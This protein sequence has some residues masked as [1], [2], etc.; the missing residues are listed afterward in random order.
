MPNYCEYDTFGRARRKTRLKPDNEEPFEVL[1]SDEERDDINKNVQQD[2]AN[3]LS[4]G[5][6]QFFLRVGFATRLDLL[7]KSGAMPFNCR[8]HSL[9]NISPLLYINWKTG[10]TLFFKVE[11][12]KDDFIKAVIEVGIHR[13]IGY[14]IRN[15][16]ESFIRAVYYAMEQAALEASICLDSKFPYLGLKKSRSPINIV[17]EHETILAKDR[18]FTQ[19]DYPHVIKIGAYRNGTECFGVGRNK[20]F[21]AVQAAQRIIVNDDSV[22]V[23]CTRSSWFRELVDQDFDDVKLEDN[24]PENA[25]RPSNSNYEAD[26]AAF[27]ADLDR[28]ASESRQ[29]LLDMIDDF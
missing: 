28:D 15:E 1:S 11:Y 10:G 23:Y 13:C 7:V 19:S 25:D 9:Q 14:S 3:I 29:E 20:Y 17:R 24:P 4:N 27:Y 26:R 22:D 21:A 18:Y 2:M 5:E 12:Y 6:H 16:N 8:D